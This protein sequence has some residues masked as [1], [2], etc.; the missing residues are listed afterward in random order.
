MLIFTL[1]D[2]SEKSTGKL[3]RPLKVLLYRLLPSPFFAQLPHDTRHF[4]VASQRDPY[5]ITLTIK[6]VK[7]ILL[8][9]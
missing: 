9:E 8:D 7:S 5:M 2:W 4:F 3:N 1:G 6:N